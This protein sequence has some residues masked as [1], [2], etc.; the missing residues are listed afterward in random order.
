MPHTRGSQRNFW[1][2]VP[3]SFSVEVWSC[4]D[5]DQALSGTVLPSLVVYAGL[6][7]AVAGLVSLIRPIRSIGIPSRGKA[8]Y[9]VAV[10]ALLAL[11][12]ALLPA[13][14]I[15][16]TRRASMIDDFLPRYQFHEVHSTDVHASPEAVYDAVKKV[17]AREIHLFGLLTWIRSPHFGSSTPSI[18]AAPPDEPLLNVA[19]RSGFMIL[20]DAPPTIWYSEQSAARPC[21]S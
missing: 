4:E 20:W 3:A 2:L 12:G 14:V 16:A 10:G 21:V 17:T 19:T 9:Y 15:A 18:L 6:L 8:G 7:V 11:F 5:G 13:P 1:P